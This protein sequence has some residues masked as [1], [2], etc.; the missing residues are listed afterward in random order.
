[1]EVSEVFPKFAV[2]G[3][4]RIIK[5]SD[6]LFAVMHIHTITTYLG[7][8]RSNTIVLN[9]FFLLHLWQTDGQVHDNKSANKAVCFF[10]RIFRRKTL[11]FLE[12]IEFFSQ[13]K[14][15]FQPKSTRLVSSCICMTTDCI[16]TTVGT[17]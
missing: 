16:Y 2:F 6:K 8:L 12:K 3:I 14:N 7:V 1:M 9:C 17:L 13:K 10:S 5:F 15:V 11:I 4:G